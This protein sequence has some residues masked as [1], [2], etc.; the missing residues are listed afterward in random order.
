VVNVK[1]KRELLELIADELRNGLDRAAGLDPR[2]RRE[3]VGLV[4][5]LVELATGLDARP[6]LGVATPFDAVYEEAQ[7]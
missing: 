3:L 1:A 4:Y 2:V 6:S 5:D 7:Q